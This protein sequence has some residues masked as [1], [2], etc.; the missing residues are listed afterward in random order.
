MG[1]LIVAG[2]GLLALAQATLQQR[3]NAPEAALVPPQAA[4]LPLRVIG[5]ATNLFASPGPS[6]SGQASTTRY[7]DCN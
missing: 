7:W 4:K 6:P 2:A 3:V 5:T 1:V